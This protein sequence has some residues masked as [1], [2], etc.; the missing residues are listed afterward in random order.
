MVHTCFCRVRLLGIALFFFFKQE[1]A[2]EM[3]IS[4]WSSDVCSSDL[5]AAG[6]LGTGLAAWAVMT[7]APNDPISSYHWAHSYSGGGGT[8]VVNVTLVDFRAF[9]TFGEII[10]LGIAALAIFALLP[11]AVRGASGRRPLEWIPDLGRSPER[12]PLMFAVATRPPIG[13]A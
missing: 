2:Y 1:T 5:G 13:T 7:R 4:D 3:R 10:V 6:G 11:T 9:D 12:P 8:N